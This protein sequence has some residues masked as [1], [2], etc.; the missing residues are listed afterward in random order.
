MNRTFLFLA[1]FGLLLFAGCPAEDG[2]G[3]DAK[4]YCGDGFVQSP[5]DDGQYEECDEG[6]LCPG[7]GEECTDDCRCVPVALAED[8]THLECDRGLCV[9]VEGGGPNECMMNS[10]CSSTGDKY[11][12]DGEVSPELGEECES[13]S[14]CTGN[15]MCDDCRCVTAPELDCDEICGYTEGAEVVGRRIESRTECAEAVNEYYESVP[16]YL[17]CRYSWYYPQENAAGWDSCCCGLVVY[18]ECTDCPGQNPECPDPDTCSL[19]TPTWVYPPD[20]D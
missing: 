2:S 3:G 13:D 12:G 10:D 18:H 20:E 14:D 5:N 7:L 17:T 15:E 11:C 4:A 19:S 16:C 6:S 8:E 1:A 9:E